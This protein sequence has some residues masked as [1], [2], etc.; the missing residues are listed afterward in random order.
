MERHEQRQLVEDI[1]DRLKSGLLHVL[2]NGSVPT[3]WDGIEL[4]EWVADYVRENFAGLI[5]RER[6]RY[7]AYLNDRVV[8]WEL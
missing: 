4:R 7:K 2:D 3:H 8:H 1:C 6:A 5:Q